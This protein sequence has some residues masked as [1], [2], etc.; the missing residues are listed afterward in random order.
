MTPNEIAVQ[1]DD[2][3][4]QRAPAIV[5]KLMAWVKITPEDVESFKVMA[6]ARAVDL[7]ALLHGG[8]LSDGTE[9]PGQKALLEQDKKREAQLTALQG[10]VDVLIKRV[11]ELLVAQAEAAKK[12]T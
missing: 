1:D 2:Q 5:R 9:V 10:R 12:A 3:D 8:K 11:D 4:A 7:K 6:R